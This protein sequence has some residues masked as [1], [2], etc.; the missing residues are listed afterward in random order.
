MWHYNSDDNIN[1]KD[2]NFSTDATDA[3]DNT[4]P[5][6]TCYN[7]SVTNCINYTNNNYTNPNLVKGL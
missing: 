6:P 4:E 5:I 1:A 3:T 2:A 7:Y